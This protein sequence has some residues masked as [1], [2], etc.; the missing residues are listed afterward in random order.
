[1]PLVVIEVV[2]A[3]NE[4]GA[5][6]QVGS[7]EADDSSG[8]ENVV[9]SVGVVVLDLEKLE[10]GKVPVHPGVVASSGVSSK[11]RTLESFEES[12]PVSYDVICGI[13]VVSNSRIQII[14]QRSGTIAILLLFIL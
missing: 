14:L 2:E 8:V 3:L 7:S 6:L 11:G 5:H 9:I 12:M 13:G 10:L 4:G 1:M